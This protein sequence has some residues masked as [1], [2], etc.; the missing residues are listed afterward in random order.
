MYQAEMPREKIARNISKDFHKHTE[1]EKQILTQLRITSV[2]Y[3]NLL[4][5]NGVKAFIHGSV[6]RG[7]VSQSSDIDIH[8][9]YIIPSFR[10]DMIDEFINTERRIIMGTPNSTIKGL[11]K[12][13]QEI[14]L[15]FP[16]TPPTEREIDFYRFS[17]LMYLEEL[18]EKAGS[19]GVTKKLLFIEPTNTGYWYSSLL[20]HKKTV[21]K[22]LNV[23]QRIIDERIRVLT[24]RDKIG[25]TG[26]LLD[27]S[28][29]P[30]TNFEQ[31][32]HHLRSQNPIV[33]NQISR[34][35][36]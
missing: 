11:F 13:D 5:E 34:S 22:S 27:Y 2:Y 25:R 23:S 12:I 18:L 8:I 33:R 9:P 35:N 20:S 7:D 3:L 21:M 30:N 24:R 6:A 17:G 10:L 29:S 26:L 32:L 4:E 15:T 31:V 16:L 14:S 36:K 1:E 19:P 28:L